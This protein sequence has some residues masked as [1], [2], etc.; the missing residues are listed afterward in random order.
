MNK[1]Y[2][3]LLFFGLGI[4][5]AHTDCREQYQSFVGDKRN[6]SSGVAPNIPI[7][8]STTVG[9]LIL[10]PLMTSQVEGTN[11]ND[12]EF[13]SSFNA[14]TGEATSVESS[15]ALG[16]GFL[17][18]GGLLLLSSDKGSSGKLQ[19]YQLIKEAYIGSGN[20]LSTMTEL[21][22]RVTSTDLS[23]RKVAE[24][25]MQANKDKVFCETNLWDHDEVKKFLIKELRK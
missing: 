7:L 14:T 1:I 24:T 12:E 13:F 4:Q 15:Y 19:A 23:E 22:S 9:T 6:A 3:M 8:S 21:L 2:G 18:G 11:N 20:E 10:A 25:V 5:T 17:I 16:F